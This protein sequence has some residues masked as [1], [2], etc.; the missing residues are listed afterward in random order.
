[1]SKPASQWTEEDAEP[2][3]HRIALG[4]EVR[5]IV[6]RRLDRGATPG[7]RTNGTTPRQSAMMGW[8]RKAADQRCHRIFSRAA[9]ATIVALGLFPGPFRWKLRWESALPV[10]LAELKSHEDGTSHIGGRRLSQGIAVYGVPGADFKGDPKQLGAPLKSLAALKREGK[11]DVR[12]IRVE[13]FQREDGPVVVYCFL[14]SGN[15]QE[16]SAH[17]VRSTDRPDCVGPGF[18]AERNGVHGQLEL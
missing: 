13:V 6:T 11:K 14:V 9:V 10:R 7:R 12:P 1:M 4:K 3:S 5:A 16:G 15:Q 17:P 2:G 8:I 18:R